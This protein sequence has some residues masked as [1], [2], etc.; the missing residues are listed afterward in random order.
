M[1]LDRHG[2]DSIKNAIKW[3]DLR[4]QASECLDM[5]NY[6]KSQLNTE[7]E[8]WASQLKEAGTTEWQIKW[9]ADLSQ[10]ER[11]A[12]LLPI[13]SLP[14]ILWARFNPANWENKIYM[15]YST[16]KRR[17]CAYQ[18]NLDKASDKFKAIGTTSTS[19]N[20]SDYACLS[21]NH[22]YA[23]IMQLRRQARINWEKLK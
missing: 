11:Y 22:I 20:P 8:L 3:E 15:H 5:V 12:L 14:A 7:E 1:I 4:V 17:V 19:S 16:H 21:N 23:T 6:H 18:G 13:V 2:K 10:S 9:H